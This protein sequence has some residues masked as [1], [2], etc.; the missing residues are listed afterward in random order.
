MATTTATVTKLRV[1]DQAIAFTVTIDGPPDIKGEGSMMVYD[2]TGTERSRTDLGVMTADQHWDVWLELP[3]AS[4]GDGDFYARVIIVT[5]T[6]DGGF[7]D[8]TANEGVSFLVGRGRVYPS[9]EHAPDLDFIRPPTISPIRLEGSWVVFDMTNPEAY[10]LAVTHEL[11]VGQ[12]GGTFQTFRGAELLPIGAT[13]QAHYLL[14][15]GLVD[16]KYMLLV[17]VQAEG[18]AV[19]AT[20]LAYILVEGD[21]VTMVPET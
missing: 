1:E 9:T 6:S 21:V 11:M 20:G 12:Q 7:G 2:A 17:S 18:S 19:P 8:G 4:L 3:V 14:P 16:G 5:K 13:Q 15:E 10:A